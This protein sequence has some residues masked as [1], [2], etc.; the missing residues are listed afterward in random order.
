MKSSVRLLLTLTLLLTAVAVQ[1]QVALSLKLG[2]RNFL[3]YEPIIATVTLRNDSAQ[4]LVFGED[5][6][7]RGTL[8]FEITGRKEVVRSRVSEQSLVGLVLRA[9]ETK[10]IKLRL[11]D[12]YDLTNPAIYRGHVY[13]SHPQLETGFRSPDITFQVR[14]GVEVWKAT[15]GVPD[16]LQENTTGSKKKIKTRSYRLL[17]LSESTEKYYYLQIEDSKNIYALHC[18]GQSMLEVRTECE[19]DML[20]NLHILFPL[21]TQNYRYFVFDIDGRVLEQCIYHVS[22][23]KPGLFHNTETGEVTVVGG[24]RMEELKW[25]SPAEEEEEEIGGIPPALPE[26]SNEELP[27][28]DSNLVL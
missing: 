6:R 26:F 25:G 7:L 8:R 3:Q 5:P 12:Y 27:I 22:G 19:T 9:G 20:S 21:T 23:T 28:E 10:E 2:R 13:I 18:L 17:S 16:L 4:V 14:P 24:E 15:L 1:A 11:S